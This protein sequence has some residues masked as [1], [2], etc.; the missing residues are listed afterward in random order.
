MPIFKQME[1]K[2]HEELVFCHDQETGLKAIIAVHDTTIGPALGGCRMWN[3]ET[4]EDALKDVLR[5]S[6]GMSYKA[7]IA[8]LNL[9]GGKAVII[10]N[11]KKQ[12]NEL[13]FRS[14]GRFVQ[15]LAGRYI[16]AEDVGT[17]VKDMEWVRMETRYVTGISRALGGSGDP[18]PVTALGTC[19]GMKATV[20]KHLGKDTLFGLNIGIQGVGHVGYHLCNFLKKEG[21][22]LFVTDIDNKSIERVVNEFGAKPIGLDDIYDADIDIYAPCALGATLNDDTIPR[23]RCSIVAGAANNQLKKESIHSQ[24]LKDRDILYA[25][26][27]AINAGGLINVANEID[28]YNRDRAFRQ[29]E[30]GIYDTLLAIYKRSEDDGVTTHAAALKVAEKRMEDVS[31]LKNIYLPKKNVMGRRDNN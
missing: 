9:G 21:A 23:L 8:G 7:A 24:M 3:Y 18:S 30:D 12:K 19:S 5:L 15:G 4:E 17:S 14:F 6:R 1:S 29:A 16:T 27:Y 25:P 20:K 10:G 13:L 22:N 26:D 28:G 2:E 31:K 11:S